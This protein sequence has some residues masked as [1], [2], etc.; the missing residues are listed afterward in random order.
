MNYDKIISTMKVGFMAP[1]YPVPDTVKPEDKAEWLFKRSNELN[2]KT[3]DYCLPFEDTDD[4][5]SS[6]KSLM[7]RYDIEPDMRVPRSFFTLADGGAEAAQARKELVARCKS[8][9]KLGLHILRAGYG[10]NT[11]P[12]SRFSTDVKGQDQLKKLEKTLSTAAEILE[13]E[14][15][16]FALE[17]HCDFTAQQFVEVFEAVDSPYI[18]CALDTGNGIIIFND[19]NVE[20]KLLAPYVIT[21]HI[22]DMTAMAD[23][24]KDHVPFMACN[25][26]MGEGIVDIE[27]AIETVARKS[28]H[29]R[30]LHLIVETG[31][32]GAWAPQFAGMPDDERIAL[33]KTWYDTYIAK[34]L[35]FIDR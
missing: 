10:R 1:F 16:Y 32:T 15:I 35:K 12:T 30:G 4:D 19:P 5:V 28:K 26:L 22:K 31:T 25:A 14:D 9:H 13:S 2:C 20:Y 23:P 7:D 18:G 24:E 34:L 29:G 21:T 11:I 3:I 33:S 27:D 8:M 17:N 6:L